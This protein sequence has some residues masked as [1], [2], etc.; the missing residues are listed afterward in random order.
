MHKAG[1]LLH[2]NEGFFAI[3]TPVDVHMLVI[4]ID[5]PKPIKEIVV[6]VAL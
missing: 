1:D 4:A 5:G 6:K 3:F 2:V